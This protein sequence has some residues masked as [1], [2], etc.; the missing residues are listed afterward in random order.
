MAALGMW[1]GPLEAGQEQLLFPGPLPVIMS[2][3]RAPA[4]Y[5]APGVQAG[6]GKHPG[7]PE[8]SPEAQRTGEH[9]HETARRPAE[10]QADPVVHGAGEMGV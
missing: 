3:F 1:G 10:G 8:L 5:Q 7:T 2:A 9:T 4:V 6:S